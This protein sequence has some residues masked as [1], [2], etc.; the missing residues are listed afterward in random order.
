MKKKQEPLDAGAGL[1]KAPTERRKLRKTIDDGRKVEKLFTEAPTFIQEVLE[2]YF[3]S[4]KHLL[5]GYGGPNMRGCCIS[6][7]AIYRP[8][9]QCDYLDD[10]GVCAAAPNDRLL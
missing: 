6:Y 4:V 7:R 3:L 10:G 9:Y 5:C 8:E 2:I 1:V